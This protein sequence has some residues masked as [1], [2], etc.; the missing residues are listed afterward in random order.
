MSSEPPF[1]PVDYEKT[2]EKPGYACPNT[3]I[4]HNTC[5]GASTSGLG[6]KIQRNS[7]R[8]LQNSKFWTIFGRNFCQNSIFTIKMKTTSSEYVPA[9]QEQLIIH[10]QFPIQYTVPTQKK[11]G[12]LEEF[13]FIDFSPERFSESFPNG[14]YC[15]Q[16]GGGS[17]KLEKFEFPTSPVA[18]CVALD[19]VQLISNLGN[20]PRL[21]AR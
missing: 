12:I 2:R 7:S 20:Y 14:I 16:W 1:Q 21:A 4:G 11:Y 5:P 17:Q 6:W 18:S 10:F 3:I 9:T 15:F 13:Q 8:I 19:L